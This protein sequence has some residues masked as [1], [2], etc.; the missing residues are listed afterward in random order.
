MS[1]TRG[2]QI[3]SNMLSIV[4]DGTTSN[5]LLIGELLKQADLYIGEGS[6]PRHITDGFELAK[7][8]ALRVLEEI[9][10]QKSSV[11]RDTLISIAR[12]SLR[13]KLEPSL[14]DQLTE[15]CLCVCVVLNSQDHYCHQ[16]KTKQNSFCLFFW[17]FVGLVCRLTT[18]PSFLNS[19]LCIS[20]PGPCGC[21]AHHSP[22]GQ[23]P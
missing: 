7:T 8:E 15:V 23:A 5:V 17:A 4:V 1:K 18:P 2:N 14:A 22:G 10:R 21:G 16:N 3:V 11:D 13:T 6:H 9:K 20:G 19:I 12:T